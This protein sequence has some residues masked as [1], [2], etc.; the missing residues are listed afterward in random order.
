MNFHTLKIDKIVQETPDAVSIFF[1]VPPH[2]SDAYRFTAGQHLTVLAEIDGKEERRAYSLSTPPYDPRPAITVK[3]VE[4]GKMSNFLCQ[5]VSE[6]DTLSVMTP[7]GHF[8]VHPD[9]SLSRSHYF[10]AAG[11]GITPV[12][13]MISTILE[14]EPK[15]VCYLL[16]GSRNEESVI[17]RQRL[18]DLSSRYSGQLEVS[19]ILSKPDKKP[20]GGLSGFLGRKKSDWKG[21]TGRIDGNKCLDFI[22]SHPS[23]HSVQQFYICGPGSFIESVTAGLADTGIDKKNI[24][25]EYFNAGTTPVEKKQ[26]LDHAIIRVTLKGETFEMEVPKGKTVLDVLV[27]AKKDPPYSCTSGACSTCMARVTDGK[28]AMDSCFALDDDEVEA[29]YI[30]TCQAHPQSARVTLSYDV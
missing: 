22:N 2:L 18:D 15:S 12:I 5:K 17:F 9:H 24:H 28:V 4:G 21:L 3:K 30:L 23:V 1:E 25:K 20:A 29:G 26:G 6:G 7:E 11:S 8:V 13:S 10:F 19:H 14:E 16:Y 27:D